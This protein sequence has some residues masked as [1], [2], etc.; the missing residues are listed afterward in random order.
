MIQSEKKSRGAHLSTV[1]KPV[2][3][4]MSISSPSV[5]SLISPGQTLATDNHFEFLKEQQISADKTAPVRKPCIC[6]DTTLGIG[7]YQPSSLPFSAGETSIKSLLILQFC[8][9]SQQM[10][11]SVPITLLEV[12]S[13][14]VTDN[15][16]GLT[17][18]RWSCSLH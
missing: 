4:E 11:H 17:V 9:T 1:S 18:S 10:S 16:P 13:S 15:V 12:V 7:D 6:V 8:S 14:D 2:R 5:T 3:K